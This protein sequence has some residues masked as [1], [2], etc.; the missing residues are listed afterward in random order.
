MLILALFV[1]HF[2]QAQT[3]PGKIIAKVL[4]ENHGAFSN[5]SPHF[6]SLSSVLTQFDAEVVQK[7]PHHTLPRTYQQGWVNLS[8]IYEITTPHTQQ[9]DK[10]IRRLKNTSLFKYVEPKYSSHISVTPNDPEINSQPYLS[11]IKAF[12]GWDFSTGDSN[13]VIAIIDTGSDLDHPDLVENIKTRENDLVDG[14]DNDN[15]G[16]VDDYMGWD[17]IDNDNQP[18]AVSNDHG[19]HVAGLAAASTNNGIGVAGAA[20]DC[21][22]ITVRAGDGRAILYGYEG[23]VYAADAGAS[24]INCSWGNSTFSRFAEDIVRYATLNKD[25][26][27]VAAAGNDGANIDYYPAAYEY[28]LAVASIDD[29]DSKSGFS[30]YGYWVD[31]SAPGAGLYNTVKEGGYD[32]KVGTSMA[33]PLVAGGAAL[34][35]SQHPNFTALQTIEHLKATSDDNSSVSGNA[36]FQ[37]KIGSGRLNLL[38][39]LSTPLTNPAIEIFRKM[40]SDQND[41]VFQIGDTLYFDAFFMNLMANANNLIAEIEILEGTGAIQIIQPTFNIGELE[42]YEYKWNQDTPF[43]MVVLPSAAVNEEVVLSIKTF[44]GS[45][46]TEDFFR[47]NVNVDHETINSKNLALTLNSSGRFGYSELD[48]KGGISLRYKNQSPLLYEG[49]LMVGVNQ[50]GTVRVADV[51][52]NAP[53]AQ[54][55]DFSTLA[56]IAKIPNATDIYEHKQAHF[57]D[58]NSIS[59]D[60]I[61]L[62][63]LLNAYSYDLEGHENYI[64]LEYDVVNVSPG[65][66][67]NLHAGLF[68]DF[69]IANFESN[70]VYTDFQR[71]LTF[72]EFGEGRATIAGVQL[73]SPNTFTSYAID[74]TNGG[75]DGIDM[76]DGFSSGEKFIT[77]STWRTGAGDNFQFGNDV[78]QVSAGSYPTLAAGDTAK[79]IF[80]I[81]AAQ[82]I[83]ELRNSAD[84]AYFHYHGSLPLSVSPSVGT[85]PN[86]SI[87]PNPSKDFV[88]VENTDNPIERIQV[89]SLNGKLILEKKIGSY[90]AEIDL[91]ENQGVYLLKTFTKKGVSVSKIV[92]SN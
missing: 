50:S 12:E 2:T 29:D 66:R 35:R 31:I 54:D 85:N 17:F 4:P 10:L 62:A 28:V 8:L 49:G 64:L 20:H 27:V 13:T 6:E 86:V 83:E 25:A 91:P 40:I 82:D 52:R 9:T 39:A 73:I 36:S 22:F 80:A 88:F 65:P 5:A 15:N 76:N 42:T 32:Y 19:V 63:V 51:V 71:Y 14:I 60:R 16:Y 59:N 11:Q 72:T 56:D 37:H 74:N 47:F 70:K 77:L 53:N 23:I 43:E 3:I 30:N 75:F 79:F 87:Y 78:A 33:A 84:S 55:S 92:K 34:V 38:K 24:V 90:R 81:H 21:K 89:F 18:Q 67:N 26:V 7:W 58:T 41:E 48:E 45:Y 46:S 69:D 1:A 44:N 57:T 61:G 68:A